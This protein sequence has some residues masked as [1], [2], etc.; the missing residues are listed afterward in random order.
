M[1]GMDRKEYRNHGGMSYGK[2]DHGS[3]SS[4]LYGNSFVAFCTEGLTDLSISAGA[5][6]RLCG[7]NDPAKAYCGEAPL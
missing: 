6:S 7:S 1:H 2:G 3:D 4:H 5:G